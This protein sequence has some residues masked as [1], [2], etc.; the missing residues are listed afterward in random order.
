MQSWDIAYQ[1]LSQWESPVLKIQIS[2]LCLC[3]WLSRS[4]V[5]PGTWILN[6]FQHDSNRQPE[7]T[8]SPRR[9]VSSTGLCPLHKCELIDPQRNSEWIGSLLV[10][11]SEW[12]SEMLTGIFQ[13][14]QQVARGWKQPVKP[15]DSLFGECG[16]CFWRS[17]VTIVFLIEPRHI[18]ESN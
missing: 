9:L 13:R 2:R 12:D 14:H 1:S 16:T 10:S 17:S 3:V 5:G 11:S 8:A 15:Q 18:S 6:N 7:H 4:R